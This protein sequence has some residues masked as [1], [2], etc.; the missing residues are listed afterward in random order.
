MYFV[1][2]YF[3]RWDFILLLHTKINNTV[4]E[5]NANDDDIKSARTIITMT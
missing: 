2:L 3:H 5:D 1:Y 4:I